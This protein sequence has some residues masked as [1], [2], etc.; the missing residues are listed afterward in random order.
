ML[1]SIA[2]AS[3]TVTLKEPEVST[4]VFVEEGF[5]HKAISDGR[6]RENSYYTAHPL[7]PVTGDVVTFR[8]KPLPGPGCY[9]PNNL[10]C[11]AELIL[12]DEDGINPPPN[13]IRLVPGKRTFS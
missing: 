9:R 10:N 1:L 3:A 8:F 2:M 4:K 12:Y 13:N 5:F 7:N 6:Y 11:H